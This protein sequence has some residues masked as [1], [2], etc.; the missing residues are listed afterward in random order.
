MELTKTDIQIFVSMT[1]FLIIISFVFPELGFATANVSQS[2]IPEFNVSQG[3]LDFVQISYPLRAT[4]PTEGTLRYVD[5]Q[6]VYQDNRRVWLEGNSDNGYEITLTNNGTLSNPNASLFL[7]EYENGAFNRS[8]STEDSAF[9]N[10]TTLSLG[11]YVIG[12]ENVTYSNQG[13]PNMTIT[14][15]WQVEESPGGSS[16]FGS[17]PLIGGTLDQVAKALGAIGAIISWIGEMIFNLFLNIGVFFRNIGTVIYN[18]LNF[19]TGIAWWI[20]VR[21]TTVVQNAP[22]SYVQI[23]LVLPSLVWSYEFAKVVIIIRQQLP[24]I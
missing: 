3:T 22:A 2:D 19:F 6:E 5:N 21:Y 8:V 11:D 23:F 7:N 12:F 24:W 1:L 17:I 14:T 13:N 20:I 15:E 10:F 16:T 9:T 18:V 4:R